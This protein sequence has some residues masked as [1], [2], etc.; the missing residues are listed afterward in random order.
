MRHRLGGLGALLSIILLAGCAS[1]S[2]G[3]VPEA[4]ETSTQSPTAVEQSATPTPSETPAVAV[5][6]RLHDGECSRVLTD[7][8]LD[9]LLDEGWQSYEDYSAAE[10]GVD[11]SVAFPEG[12]IGGVRCTWVAPSGS[13]SNVH[14]VSVLVLPEDQVSARFARTFA[15]KQCDPSY[16]VNVCRL[17]RS[18]NGA[19]IMASAPDYGEGALGEPSD[20]FLER[21]IAAI[22]GGVASRGGTPTPVTQTEEWWALPSCDDF[23]SQMRFG[24]ITAGGFESGYWEGSEQAEQSLLSD[25]GVSKDCPYFSSS[26]RITPDEHHR[27][28]TVSVHPGG[29]W[30][31][32][33]VSEGREGVEL[34]GARMA[35][36]VPLGGDPTGVMS[37]DEELVTVY[38]TDGVNMVE[39]SGAEGLDF[40]ADIVER[41]LA[42]LAAD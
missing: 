40:A 17:A 29:H 15:V 23:A 5:P 10:Y 36:A 4:T 35:V 26:D 6:D 8:E 19:W 42:A 39:V 22:A 3:P 30:M 21:V 7:A 25:A 18:V 33:V 12:T 27:I 32:E 31:W 41:A 9:E 1:P 28:F 13:S 38:A 2:V 37:P 16:D 24:E 34:V 20:A 14:N 11:R